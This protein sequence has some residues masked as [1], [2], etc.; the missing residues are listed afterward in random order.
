MKM[1]LEKLIEKLILP[2]G[3]LIGP[4]LIIRTLLHTKK[5]IVTLTYCLSQRGSYVLVQRIT[6]I[7]KDPNEI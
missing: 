3:R 7:N 2:K 6:L 1:F 4:K 5:Q